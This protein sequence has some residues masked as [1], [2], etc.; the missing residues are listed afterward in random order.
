MYSPTGTGITRVELAVE[1]VAVRKACASKDMIGSKK[2][3]KKNWKGK[4]GRARGLGS[5]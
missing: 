4:R 1:I 3:E 2:K 5:G